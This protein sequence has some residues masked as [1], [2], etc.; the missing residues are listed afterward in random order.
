MAFE[1]PVSIAPMM[2]RTD[3]H[4][5]YF[6][7]G[8][9]KRSLLYTEMV[10]MGAILNGDRDYLLGFDHAEHPISL[11]LGGDDPAKMSECAQI[12]EEWGYDEVNINVGCPSDRVQNGNFGACL[13]SQPEVVAACVDAMRNAVSIPVTVKH[14]IGID[15]L[16]RY[17]DMERFVR[18]VADAGCKRFTVHA[19]KAWLQGLSPKENRNVPPLRYPE[20]YRLKE[21]FPQLVIEMNG[22]IKTIDA[23]VEHLERLDAVMLGRAAYDDPYLFASVDRIFYGDP[24]PIPTR[25]GAVERM[26]EYCDVWAARGLKMS[27]VMRHM[28]HLFDGQP[29]ARKWRQH[30]SENAHRDGADSEV[31]RT[32]LSFVD[33][34]DCDG[35]KFPQA[36]ATPSSESVRSASL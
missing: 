21:A 15:D 26:Y 1:H 12:A 4:Y 5:R 18:I 35:P 7:R 33:P 9:T 28:L 25:H 30:I 34:A 11:Q 29:G 31:L 19:R 27:N 16:D 2:K 8:L 10:T 23:M 24:S 22:G 32:A 20:I 3:R 6:M 36:E 14:R 17:E 13:M